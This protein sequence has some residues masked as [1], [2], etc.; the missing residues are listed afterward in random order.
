M[1]WLRCSICK[2]MKTETGFYPCNNSRGYRYECKECAKKIRDENRKKTKEYNRQWYVKNKDKKLKQSRIW[3]KNNSERKKAV[4]KKYRDK[5][6]KYISEWHRKYN[7]ENKEKIKEYKQ[8]YYKENR[9][10]I[11]ARC[12]KYN[13]NR[14]RNDIN[15]RLKNNVS[16]SILDAL[17]GSKN[18][19]RTEDI[20]GYP[21]TVMK[22]W[23]EQH[24]EDWMNWENYG[25][26]DV[27]KRTWQIDH[28]IPQSLYNFNNLEE[29]KKCWHYRNLRPMDSLKNLRKNNK[30]PWELIESEGLGDLL[31]EKLLFED[32]LNTKVIKGNSKV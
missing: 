26:A 14:A 20:I 24:F 32:I 1:E 28:I 19:K 13:I 16:K 17:N 30:I 18:R 7:I 10:K 29:I 8:R 6:K 22:D 27:N 31:P 11:L 23:L 4:D 3:K 21:I 5:N 9:E 15:F 25:R 12:S 2:C